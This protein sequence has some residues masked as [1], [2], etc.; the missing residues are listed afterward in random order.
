VK[1]QK[2]IEQKLRQ[3]ETEYIQNKLRTN[4]F[5]DEVTEMAKKILIERNAE[6]PIAETE[7]ESEEKH[8]NNE[9]VSLILFALFA[10]YV[11]VLWFADY[12]FTRFVIFT[13]S[14]I[15]AVAYTRSLRR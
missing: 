7:E 5:N 3:E 13:L 9:K 15:G 10:T 6:I 14:L 4:S 12:S 11:L 1:D 8:K 2:M